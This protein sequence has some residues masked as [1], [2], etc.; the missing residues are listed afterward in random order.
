MISKDASGSAPRARTSSTDAE[1]C[2]T[3]A[4]IQNC[5]THQDRFNLAHEDAPSRFVRW[6]DVL[7]E[8][9][10]QQLEQWLNGLFCELLQRETSRSRACAARAAT[11]RRRRSGRR[12][13]SRSSSLAS[14][15]ARRLA[16]RSCEATLDP[17]R[18]MVRVDDDYPPPS[19]ERSD[20][21]TL[22][23]A[24]DLALPTQAAARPPA[25]EVVECGANATRPD[26]VVRGDAVAPRS[27]TRRSIAIADAI[28]AL[29][30]QGHSIVREENEEP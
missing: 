11:V 1:Q 13:T 17:R 9:V 29:S 8:G 22:P 25:V 27:A 7:C 10:A 12:L 6:L 19:T 23:S 20:P 18:L 16:A 21:P 15:G 28:E 24:P 4:G 30:G 26:A 3:P 2:S 14:S 5:R